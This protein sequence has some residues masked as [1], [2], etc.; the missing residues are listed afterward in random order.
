MIQIPATFLRISVA[1]LAALSCLCVGQAGAAQRPS[2][3]PNILV[4]YL[5]DFG[6]RDCGFMGSDFFETPNLDRLA[7]QGTVFTDAYAGAANCAPSRAC[8]MS[9]QYTP[10]HEIFNVGT[11][12]RGKAQHRRLLHV[13]GTD[14]LRPSITTWPQRLHAAG[15]KTALMGKWHLSDDPT[16][17]GFDINVGGSHS[18]SPPKGYYPPHPNAPGL[19]DA[20]E[21]EYLTDRL[22][23]EAVKFIRRSADQT[24]M[25]YLTHFAVHTPLIAKRELVAKYESKP[26]GELHQHVAMATMIEAVDQGIGRIMRTI[27]ELDLDQNTVI[28]FSSD[29][30]G[31]GPATDMHPLKG[32]KG[33]YYEGGIRV[34]MFVRWPGQVTAG[35]RIDTPVSQLD[36]YPTI[37]DIAGLERSDDQSLDGVSLWPMLTE[38]SQTLASRALFWHFPAY[39]QGYSNVDEQRD[40]LF[41]TRPCGIIRQGDWK[42]HEY[43]ES[44]DLEL[45]NLKDDI[46]ETKNLA[47]S[48]PDKAAQLHQAMIRWRKRTDAP[49]PSTANPKFDAEAEAKAI[50]DVQRKAAKNKRNR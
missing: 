35:R 48:M 45:Y 29:N 15:Y 20:P 25:L 50:A 39:L 8:L 40:P 16:Q 1:A 27:N 22:S 49:V 7:E 41:R 32:Y 2:D 34:P 19:D 9:G 44:G 28:L 11:G 26:A 10:R 37:L 14:T 21:D 18:G 5:D 13:P 4:I 30:G 23:D 38:P 17:Y 47:D 31:Y 43:F 42:L 33:T 24:W 3:R 36:W 6:W 12:P 46:G